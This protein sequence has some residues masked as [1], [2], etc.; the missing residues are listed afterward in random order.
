MPVSHLTFPSYRYL[1]HFPSRFLTFLHSCI[2]AYL[3]TCILAFV[4]LCVPHQLHRSLLLL[5][6]GLIRIAPLGPMIL[7]F[8]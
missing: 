4:L 1:L 6:L 8:P 5:V 2:L 3:H 7:R